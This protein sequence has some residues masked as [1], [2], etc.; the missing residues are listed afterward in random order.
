MKKGREVDKTNKRDYLGKKATHIS[1]NRSDENRITQRSIQK[2]EERKAM[3][4]V[5]QN[6]DSGN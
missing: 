4:S 1:R 5:E 6:C 2:G 3:D